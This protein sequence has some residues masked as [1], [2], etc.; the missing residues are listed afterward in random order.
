[1][2]TKARRQQAIVRLIEQVEV[3]NQVQLV[4]LLAAEGITATQAITS[5]ISTGWCSM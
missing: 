5:P 3:A 1:M 2:S 4:D